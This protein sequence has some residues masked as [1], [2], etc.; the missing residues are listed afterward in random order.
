VPVQALELH[1]VTRHYLPDGRSA[2]RADSVG[3]GLSNVDLTVAPGEIHAL[4]GM[5]GAGKSTLMKLVVGMLRAQHGTIQVLG[6]AVESAGPQTWAR[7][8]ALIEHPFGYGEL[9][10]RTNLVLAA[11]LR[12]VP[13]QSVPAMVE[14]ILDELDLG[15]YAGRRYQR[16][17]QGNRQRLGLAAALAHNPALVVLD[18]PTN[19]LDPAGIIA[20]RRALLRRAES[21]TGILVSSHHLDEVARIAHRISV[22]ADGR[23]VGSLDPTGVD[24]ERS[25]FSIVRAATGCTP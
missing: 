7:V 8:G 21:G 13:V 14:G 9:D 16:M 25:F 20:L 15:R 6:R 22:L 11:R 1:A 4:V 10:A 17:S 18:E 19:S 3:A 5:N 2:R 12:A 24:I 23:L